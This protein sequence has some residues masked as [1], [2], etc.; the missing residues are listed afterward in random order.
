MAFVPLSAAASV[1]LAS[2]Y[3]PVTIPSL[4]KTCYYKIYGKKF[5]GTAWS[6]GD[7]KVIGCGLVS[8]P[9]KLD[10][11]ALPDGFGTIPDGVYFL[12]LTAVDNADNWMD[13]STYG[14]YRVDT[15]APKCDVTEV[16]LLS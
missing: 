12:Q 6:T 11:S 3:A 13:T 10:F 15:S 7:W 14:A 1:S 16:R 2:A 5:D 4:T 9:S 8:A